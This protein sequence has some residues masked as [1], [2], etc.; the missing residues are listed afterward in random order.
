[1]GN[2]LIISIIIPIFNVEKYLSKCLDSVINQTYKNLE[3]ICINDGSKDDSYQ[4]LVEYAQRDNR[5]KIINQDNQGVSNARNNGLRIA[6]GKYVYFLDS[7]DT[8]NDIFMETSF[9]TAERNNSD[10]VIVATNVFK[11]KN[12]IN[13]DFIVAATCELF[14]KKELLDRHPS[15]RY[16]EKI[17]HNEDGIFNHKLLCVTNKLN[18]NYEAMYYY[19]Q[20]FGQSSQLINKKNKLYLKTIKKVLNI[21][22]DFHANYD[23]LNDKKFKYL[24]LYIQSDIIPAYWNMDLNKEEKKYFFNSIMCFMAKY[25]LCNYHFKNKNNSNYMAE[26]F[27]K[28]KNWQEFEKYLILIK[29]FKILK[30]ILRQEGVYNAT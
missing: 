2:N 17:Q 30:K 26:R 22:E 5:I 24:S 27:I 23:L 9:N 29:C 19:T 7:D 6:T 25:T 16:P 3:I 4:I 13:E 1:M 20:R 12:I 11:R 18:I 15:I 10:I 8:I 28:C 21:L 14:I